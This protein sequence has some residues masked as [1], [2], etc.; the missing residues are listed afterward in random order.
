MNPKLEHDRSGSYLKFGGLELELGKTHRLTLSLDRVWQT[1][2]L[3]FHPCPFG[4]LITQ[5]Y[6]DDVPLFSNN[7]VPV[8]LFSLSSTF[9]SLLFPRLVRGSSVVAE[10][11]TAEPVGPFAIRLYGFVPNSGGSKNG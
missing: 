4:A 9:P 8:E 7:G 11:A 6:F 1:T 2:R 10:L 5:F 3:V